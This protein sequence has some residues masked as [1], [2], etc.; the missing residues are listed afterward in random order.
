MTVKADSR[1]R[2]SL[3]GLLFDARKEA[4]LT[5]R[6]LAARIGKPQSYVSKYESGERR[7][8]VVEF[9]DLCEVLAVSP[10]EVIAKLENR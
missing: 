8:E 4:R 7:L 1:R 2:D 9:L 5:Q 3:R 10:H 6:E